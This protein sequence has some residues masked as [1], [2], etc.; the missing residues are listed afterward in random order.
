MQLR[1]IAHARTGDKG[2]LV[3]IA[4]IAYDPAK[5][6]LLRRVV[7]ARRV[8]EWFGSLVAGEVVRYELPR[9]GALNFVF[10]RATGGVTNSLVLDGHGKSLGFLLLDMPV[11]DTSM[12]HAG[13]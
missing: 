8:H 3:N 10:A 7:S 12:R 6:E 2:N 11:D 1:E 4:L 13:T 9:L 5:F